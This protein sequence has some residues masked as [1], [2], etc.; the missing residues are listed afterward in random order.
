M[1]ELSNLQIEEIIS[2]LRKG[3][4]LPADQREDLIRQLEKLKHSI[5]FDAKKEYELIYSDKDR[6]EDILADTMAVPLQK[7]KTFRNG[8][9]S[10]IPL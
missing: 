4:Q 9:N 3:K 8:D 6:E 2:L 5:L 1:K 10:S 7:V